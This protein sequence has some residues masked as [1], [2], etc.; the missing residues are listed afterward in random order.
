[1]TESTIPLGRS[2]GRKPSV[3]RNHDMLE[4]LK[5]KTLC[6]NAKNPQGEMC[7]PSRRPSAAHLFF[8]PI[9]TVP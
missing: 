2:V 3:S 7:G 5:G 4:S 6:V 8:S 9:G 1:M